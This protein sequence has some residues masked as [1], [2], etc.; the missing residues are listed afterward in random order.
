MRDAH[1]LVG[2]CML[3]MV[4][5]AQAQ[6]AGRI[7]SITPACA[8]RGAVATIQ[9]TGFGAS[10]V[11]VTAGGVAATV[12]SATGHSA[13]FVVPTTLASG[14]TV[15]SAENPGGHLGTIAFR[16]QG[17][18]ICGN[19]VDEDCDGTI[20]D[21]DVCAPV[22]HPP[23]ANAGPDQTGPVGTTI[24]LTGA[25]SSDPD[26]NP[27]TF[28]WTLPTRP[29]TSTAVLVGATTATPSFTIDKAGT[30]VASLTVSDGQLSSAP[31]T[32]VVSTTNSAPVANA[33]PSQ[34]GYVGA[35]L[36]LDGSGSTDVDG[37]LLTYSWTLS[38]RPA[39]STATLTNPTSLHPTVTLDVFG[40]YVAQLVVND[41]RV[42]S[43][44]ATVTLSTLNS[45]PV[46]DAGPAQSATV[47]T[48]V[49]LDGS[50]SHDVDGNTLTYAWALTT[51][52]AGS[53]ATLGDPIA[54]QPTFVVDRFGTYVA[55]L[56]V[57]DGLASSA[58]ATVT[59]NPLNSPPV[60][61]AGPD[62]TGY[63]GS[64]LVL[65]GSGSTD[66][67]G[68]PL[69]YRWAVLTR[70][71]GST[72]TLSETLAVQPTFQLDRA[73]AYVVQLLVNDGTVDSAPATTTL[74]TQN[75]KP[76]ADAGPA[77]SAV[78]GSTITLD[79]SGSSDVDGDL[80]TYTWALTARPG[81]STTTLSDP[82]AVRPTF[83]L[84]KAGT[85]VAQLVVNDGTVTGDPATTT[86]TT[87]NSKP[88]ADAG[89]DQHAAVGTLVTLDGTGS[90]DV[91]G[92]ALS[93]RWAITTR[94][95]GSTASLA[96]AT[97]ARPTL[98]LDR[99]GTYV[100]ALVTNDGTVDG[101]PDTVIVT[102]TN[103]RPMADAGSDQ[104]AV[105]GQ[106]VTLDGSA[107]SDVDGDGLTYAWALVSSPAGSQAALSAAT[108][109][110]ASLVPDVAGTYVVQLT[111]ND[112]HVDSI[113]D[114]VVVSVVPA[115]PPNLPPTAFAGP[116]YLTGVG[117]TVTVDGGGGFDPE[118]A[119]LTFSW[120]LTDRPAGSS[121]SLLDLATPSPSLTPDVPGRYVVRLVVNDGVQD[122]APSTTTVT[123]TTGGSGVILVITEPSEGS[124]VHG[125]RV[126]VRGTVQA[127]PNVGVSVN[128][129][130]AAFEGGNFATI[131]PLATGQNVIDVRASILDG[132]AA[133][134]TVTVTADGA[135]AGLDLRADLKSGVVPMPVHFEFE[136]S[137]SIPI[138]TISLDS[139]GDGTPELVT[140]D[141][142]APL[143][144][145]YS[146]PG[147]FV[148]HLKI[149]DADGGI[150]EAD[151][152][153]PA[154][155]AAALDGLL[156]A[157]WDA[158]VGRLH[159]A[160]VDGALSYIEPA[161][162]DSFARVFN[163]LA[164][165]LT[166]ITTG[167]GPIKGR[168]IGVDLAEYFIRRTIDGEPRA[169]FVYFVRDASG[170]WRIA[171]M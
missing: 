144:V 8:A 90:T 22:N 35:T 60:A 64:T 59:I 109:A 52:P 29:A 32:V 166:S 126:L 10:G 31:D 18:E 149:V 26:G 15:V 137:S 30:Y 46:A 121:A 107:S 116:P 112:G 158:M 156:V 92:D 12:S 4:G 115:G 169:F 145:V 120:V 103:T 5:V 167:F 14:V 49:T 97:T 48:V 57:N 61:N 100:I 134:A 66:V 41:G 75:S 128:G 73:G 146:T 13:T 68:N 56:V 55:Q 70:P 161:R 142:T 39:G 95:A 125:T 82:S 63:V 19:E 7:A 54:V 34:T 135:A 43:A 77:Q 106:T 89:P 122:S 21:P 69:T 71:A 65:D 62:Q 11:T 96:S 38:A 99:P 40:A 111:V 164:G 16:I 83:A 20:D 58:P 23:V 113:A 76:V 165:D 28:T 47:G 93:Y 124:S 2:W 80:L 1:W 130:A 136:R 110:Y 140:T 24:H 127:P 84:D 170:V 133:R 81:G 163:V 123:A 36:T 42:S 102:T 108:T 86:I 153:V 150:A 157:Q 50:G 104:T 94:P 114:T 131:V 171:E 154:H 74:T 45:A 168:A 67:D 9:G 129:Q 51:R 98:A 152:V 17:P 78:V 72:T 87:L 119:P 117:E 159:A 138:Q 162:R 118:G 160:D 6:T 132:Q 151:A 101:D 105:V 139:D 44:L 148:A 53:T 88:I 155:D 91:D 141:A 25:A 143:D 37:D 79:G 27:L 33:G 147:T 3:A 85:Y